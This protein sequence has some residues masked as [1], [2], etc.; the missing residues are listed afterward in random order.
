VFVVLGE[1]GGEVTG[2]VGSI[3][4]PRTIHLIKSLE[5]AMPPLFTRSNGT[6]EIK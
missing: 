2:V 4:F 1:M 3:C 5:V 6:K